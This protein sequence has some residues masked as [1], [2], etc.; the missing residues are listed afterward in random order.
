MKINIVGG[1]GLMGRMHKSAFEMAG[2][3]VIIS[4]RHTNLTPEAAARKSDIT[5]IS[6]PISKTEEI[7]KKVAPYCKAIMDFTSLKIFPINAMLNYSSGKCEV[8]GLHP[9]YGEV[10]SI[11]GRTIIY[12]PTE[13]S[14]DRC[15]EIIDCLKLAGA[16]IK[17]MDPEKHDLLVA[18]ISQSARLNLLEGFALLVEESGIDLNELY[19]ISPPPTKILINLLARQVDES[20]DILY[21]ELRDNNPFVSGIDEILASSIKHL[22]EQKNLPERIRKLFGSELVSY[23]KKAKKIIEENKKA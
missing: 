5:I 21:K 16:K 7:I 9:L 15:N 23:Q 1:N 12:C 13:R 14:G 6:V 2:H 17:E 19:E 18:G 11:R 4:G 8:G 3:E 20:K 22:R 10:D